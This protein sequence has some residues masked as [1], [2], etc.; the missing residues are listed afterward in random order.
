MQTS[1]KFSKFANIDKPF[2]NYSVNANWSSY[3]NR[4]T[5]VRLA[6]LE[7]LGAAPGTTLVVAATTKVSLAL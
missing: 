3:F 5:V 4:A 7:A 2:F 1:L 6:F